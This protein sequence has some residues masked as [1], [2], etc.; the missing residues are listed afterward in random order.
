MPAAANR[1]PQALAESL[2]RLAAPM[3]PKAP[4]ISV[5]TR[6]HFRADRRREASS[7]SIT[8]FISS[9]D[10]LV[11]T[12]RFRQRASTTTLIANTTAKN[13]LIGTKSAKSMVLLRLVGRP[14]PPFVAMD[15][16]GAAAVAF[17]LLSAKAA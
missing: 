6:P 8:D 5:S 16:G 14:R 15:T 2:D 12:R 7:A 9:S 10:G 17:F 3:M 1:M 13:R 4:P 11:S